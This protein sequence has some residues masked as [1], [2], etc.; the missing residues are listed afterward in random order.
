MK[1]LF[2]YNDTNDVHAFTLM[3]VQYPII[4]QTDS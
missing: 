2:L 4:L 3:L 1:C